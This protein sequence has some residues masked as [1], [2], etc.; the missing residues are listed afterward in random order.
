[1]YSE[2]A[3]QPNWLITPR[4]AQDSAPT[5]QSLRKWDIF[6]N[7]REIR[8]NTPIPQQPVQATST[9][10]NPNIRKVTKSTEMKK[11]VVPAKRFKAQIATEPNS[12]KATMQLPNNK[13][14]MNTNQETQAPTSQNNP[15]PL[16]DAPICTG[17]PWPKAGKMLG[18]LFEHKKRLA[19]P[20]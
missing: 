14:P 20:S 6:R 10:T 8:S 2:E 3:G 4:G 9:N 13:A 19:N 17:T 15:P 16:E 11:R 12:G 5:Q 1:M 18:N 7:R